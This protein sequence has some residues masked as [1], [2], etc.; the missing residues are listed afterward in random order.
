LVKDEEIPDDG[1]LAEVEA[2]RKSLV[3]V[4]DSVKI[5]N[6]FPFDPNVISFSKMI[7]IGLSEYQAN[8][9]IKYRDA[10]GKFYDKDDFRKIYSITEEDFNALSSFIMI[11]E[12]DRESVVKAATQKIVPR[13]FNPND[14]DSSLLSKIGLSSKQV[15]HILNYRKA[16]GKFTVKSDFKKIYSISDND[17]EKLQKYILLPSKIDSAEIAEEEKRNEDQEEFKRPFVEI[18]SADTNELT[19]LYGIGP[20]YA[21]KIIT[22]RES[23]GGF[24]D[25]AQLLEVFG[26]DSSRFYKFEKQVKVDKSLINKLDLNNSG[27]KEMLNHPYFEYYLVKAIFNYKDAAGGFKSTSD[28]KQIDLLYD[29][30]FFKIEPYLTVKEELNR[31]VNE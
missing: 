20:Y 3:Q 29:E 9:I 21:K 30:L 16:G 14:A 7:E 17:Y 25:K 15:S 1:F 26:I 12:P 18:N 19:K 13:P 5:I 4:D 11:A 31:G 23:L 24:Y 22:Y 10:G 6:P 28:L 27:F 8:M 2:F